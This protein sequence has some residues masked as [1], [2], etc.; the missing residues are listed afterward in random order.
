[1]KK[2]IAIIGVFV[3]LV[4]CAL[5]SEFSLINNQPTDS[6][7]LGKWVDNS[8]SKDT[9]IFKAN[10]NDTFSVTVLDKNGKEHIY[11]PN[12]FSTTINGY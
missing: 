4:S 12:A 5:E 1:M 8:E 6:Q 11:S 2:I 9:L 3:L 7:L 10:D